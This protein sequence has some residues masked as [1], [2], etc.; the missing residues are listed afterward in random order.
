MQYPVSP[1]KIRL[2]QNKMAALG[3]REWEFDE[4]FVRASGAGGQNVNKVAT[5]VV[6]R[7]VPTGLEARSQKERS[8]AL[9]RFLAKRAL[10]DKIEAV[11]L[12]RASRIRQEVEKIRRQKRKRSK[13]AKQK[14]LADKTR[15]SEKKALRSSVRDYT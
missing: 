2:L 12:G 4:T 14:M 10:V 9:N 1:S 13:R 7:H 15:H 8:Q 6:I 11:R 5:C 3:L